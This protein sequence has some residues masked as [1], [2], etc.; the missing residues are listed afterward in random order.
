MIESYDKGY[1]I[2]GKVL[3]SVSSP[4]YG[5]LIK[6]DINGNVI[7]NKKFGNENN[8]N[9]IHGIDKT[10]NGGYVITGVTDRY[11]NNTSEWDP[12]IM[13]LNA[14]GEKEWCKVFSTPGNMDFGVRVKA[15]PDG[16]IMMSSYYGYNWDKRIWLFRLDLDGNIVWQN[17]YGT[18]DTLVNS[19]DCY[20][21]MITSDNQCLITGSCY[22]PHSDSNYYLHP[23]LVKTDLDGNETWELPWGKDMDF[24]CK[25]PWSITREDSRGNYY[26]P[27]CQYIGISGDSPCL[28]KTSHDGQELYY[29]IMDTTTIYGGCT[30]LDILDSNL[31]IG[32]NWQH[33][34]D[35]M[36]MGAYKTDTL[37]NV[38]KQKE[39]LNDEGYQLIGSLI[40][41]DKKIVVAGGFYRNNRWNIYLWKLNSDL[42]YDSI[43]TQPF[44]Y[45][46]LCNHAIVS[47]TIALDCDIVVD[48]N[49]PFT[50][51]EKSQLK[52]YPNPAIISFTIELPQYIVSNSKHGSISTSHV[53][54]QW[55]QGA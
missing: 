17:A 11:D 18:S 20:E 49:E 16:Y 38:I 52:V 44:T 8:R 48:I 5:L 42:E 9:I 6:T 12:F 46:S 39:L 24:Y 13:K 31:I 27:G 15:F 2:T 30:T 4:R 43:Y 26:T 55:R 22:Y 36:K 1:L 28:I 54:Y 32:A 51:P 25:T 33:P 34:G 53:L 35:T 29:G 45:D 37:G 23:F 3:N 19:E 10:E 14:C 50:Q 40:T 47:D 41:E 7:W 21:L